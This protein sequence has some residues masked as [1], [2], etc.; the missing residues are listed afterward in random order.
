MV[1]RATHESYIII[2]LTIENIHNEYI[3][4]ILYAHFINGCCGRSE[5]MFTFSEHYYLLHCLISN[6][7]GQCS[8]TLLYCTIKDRIL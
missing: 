4:I 5:L 6:F 2:I 1:K 7:S 8:Y 3:I